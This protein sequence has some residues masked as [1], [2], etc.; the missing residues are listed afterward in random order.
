[1][2][3]KTHKRHTKSSPHQQKVRLKLIKQSLKLTTQ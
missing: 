1:M 3:T 2:M